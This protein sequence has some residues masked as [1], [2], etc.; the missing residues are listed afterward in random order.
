MKNYNVIYKVNNH[1]GEHLVNTQFTLDEIKKFGVKEVI[2]HHA[3]VLNIGDKYA[4]HIEDYGDDRV[5]I[6]NTWESKT[7]V[8]KSNKLNTI[9]NLISKEAYNRIYN[10]I[11]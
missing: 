6:G 7:A 11:Q 10:S 9:G 4:C 5:L 2:R 1:H 8:F 3:K